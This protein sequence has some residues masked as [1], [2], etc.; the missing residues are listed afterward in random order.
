[1]KNQDKQNWVSKFD[2]ILNEIKEEK[3]K[4]SQGRVNETGIKE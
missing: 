3:V 1:M 2:D 4:P